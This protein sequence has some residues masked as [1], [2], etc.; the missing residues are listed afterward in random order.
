MSTKVIRKRVLSGKSD[1]IVKKSTRKRKANPVKSS[2][3]NDPNEQAD[4]KLTERNKPATGKEPAHEQYPLRPDETVPP[5]GK[6][7]EEPNEVPD[8][9]S[10]SSGEQS[11]TQNTAKNTNKPATYV[12]VRVKLSGKNI[13]GVAVF[14]EKERDEPLK[15]AGF[16]FV[17]YMHTDETNDALV[18]VPKEFSYKKEKPSFFGINRDK[19]NATMY[20]KAF[21]LMAKVLFTKTPEG[22]V[23]PYVCN[24]FVHTLKKNDKG[25]FSVFADEFGKTAVN[26]KGYIEIARVYTN[27]YVGWKKFEG[28]KNVVVTGGRKDPTTVKGNG[29]SDRTSTP[30]STEASHK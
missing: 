13:E 19:D 4:K 28:T 1:K 2:A 27:G 10:E 7:L 6:P 9:K 25:Q 18:I 16:L 8:G 20:D 22:K 30:A 23:V 21:A 12:K 3:D 24:S 11:E 17:G 14:S 5:E 15:N 29:Q 26:E